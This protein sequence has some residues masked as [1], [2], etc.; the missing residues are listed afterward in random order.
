[1]QNFNYADRVK[2][3]SPAISQDII[4]KVRALRAE[5]VKVID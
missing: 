3:I 2:R 1:M 5:G 4:G